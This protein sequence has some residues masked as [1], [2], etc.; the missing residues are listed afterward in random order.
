MLLLP[1]VIRRSISWSEDWSW[2][3]E[4]TLMKTSSSSP[5][6]VD[7]FSMWLQLY[8]LLY[9]QRS[10]PLVLSP[11]PPSPLGESGSE[12]LQTNRASGCSSTPERLK[13]QPAGR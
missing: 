1:R 9:N 5:L 4:D 10:G 7:S 11:P 6:D 2:R 12:E 3:A 8:R 13:E